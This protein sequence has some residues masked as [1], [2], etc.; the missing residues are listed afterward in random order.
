MRNDPVRWKKAKKKARDKY[1]EKTQGLPDR[2]RK[3][4]QEPFE[5]DRRTHALAL[6][7][8]I[9]LA[10]LKPRQCEFCLYLFTPE[11]ARQYYCKE[12]EADVDK[13]KFEIIEY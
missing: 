7:G 11:D 12:C 2:R 5:Y 4:R 6:I 1:R 10:I 8:G 9:V 13:C 3:G